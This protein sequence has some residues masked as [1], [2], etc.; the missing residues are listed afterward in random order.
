MGE[1]MRSFDWETT[2][3]GSVSIWPAALKALVDVTLASKQPMYVAWGPDLTMIYNDAYSVLLGL[4]H[5][6]ALGTGFLTVWSEIRADIAPLVDKVLA[7][8]PVHMDD[9]TLMVD[10]DGSEREAHFAFSYTPIRGADGRVVGLLCPCTDTTE[11]VFADRR[12]ALRLALEDAIRE[13]EEPEAILSTA[14]GLPR[15]ALG[16]QPRRLRRGPARQQDDRPLLALSWTGWPRWTVSCRSLNFRRADCASPETRRHRAKRGR[17]LGPGVRRGHLDESIDTRAFVS[18]PL[19]RDRRMK[20][21]LYVHQ[22]E[23][24]RWLPEDVTLIET[25]ATA[26]LGRRGTSPGRGGPA[27]QRSAVQHVGASLAEP[28]LDLAPR[29][30]PRLVQRADLRVQRRRARRTRR[31]WLGQVGPPR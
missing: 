22:R 26:C 18:V 1:R 25:V 17:D 29:R 16:G 12:Q 6:M 30:P 14:V 20:A 13:L 28:G 21:V 23:P 10:R 27:G 19:I 3:L 15:A 2:P 8:E 4:K 7:G 24:R 11:Q 5:P 9:I 31:R